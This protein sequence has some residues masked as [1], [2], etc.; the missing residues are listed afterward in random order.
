MA[1]TDQTFLS[2]YGRGGVRRHGRRYSF[3]IENDLHDPESFNEI[4]VYNPGNLAKD[5]TTLAQHISTV[6]DVEVEIV[7]HLADG[8]ANYRTIWPER[9]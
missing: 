9:W 8:D 6:L 5:A 7:K 4:C 2:I 3:R 1:R